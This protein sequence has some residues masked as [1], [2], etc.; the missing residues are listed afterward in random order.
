VVRCQLGETGALDELVT[1][2]HHRLWR[3][4]RTLLP[5]DEMAGDAIQDVWL[6]ILRGLPKLR[7]PTRFRG[8]AYTISHHVVMEQLRKKYADALVEPLEDQNEEPQSV[9]ADAS[10]EL[11]L[12]ALNARLME[13]PLIERNVLSLF[14]L[15]E[16]S[17]TEIAAVADVPVGTIKSRLFRA[18][19][20]LRE[21]VAATV[22][23]NNHA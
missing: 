17:L 13:L 9:V 22:T 2:W 12:D 20:M 4:I 16:L 6:G 15:Q 10:H 14:Y 19:R 11:E 1:R 8:W 5:D 23:E 7:D 3:Y 21:L 18:R